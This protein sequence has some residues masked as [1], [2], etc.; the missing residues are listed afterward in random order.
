MLKKRCLGI[1]VVSCLT[2]GL[3]VP[4]STKTVKAATVPIGVAYS[5]H[6]QN[7]GWQNQVSDGAESGTDGKSLRLEGLKIKLTG[8]LPTGAS[9]QYQT[10][11]ENIGWQD[12]ISNG[13]EAGTDGKGLREEAIR[14]KLVNLPGYSVQ[15]RV[16]VQNIG[17]QD[18]VSDGALAGTVGQ[19]L[20]LEA[21][22][23]RIV[24]NSYSLGETATIQDTLWGTYEL[25]V[26][27]V[28]LTTERNPYESSNPAEVYKITYTYKL[29]SKGTETNMGLYIYNFDSVI[30]ST[31]STGQEY[32]GNVINYP[33]ELNIVG[34]SCT[35]ETFV[36][37][38]NVTDN[39]ILTK[40]Y[41][42]DT[43]DGYTTFVIPTK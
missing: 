20:R 14:I 17:W 19:G 21:L 8:D 22:E 36:G 34:T 24:K 15:Y 30:D 1:F 39:L 23:V 32:P 9:I 27:K 18:W 40:N 25:T 26:N 42:T 33:Q 10:Q 2:I 41:F 3:L 37:V 13:Q 38:N 35:A 12:W 11:V 7:I 43:G 29:L 31:G 5:S 16:H 4:T 6:I 28:E